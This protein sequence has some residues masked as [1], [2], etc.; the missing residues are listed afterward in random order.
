M[1]GQQKVI[2]R[3]EV[4][5]QFPNYG[6]TLRRVQIIFPSSF[7]PGPPDGTV[8]GFQELISPPGVQLDQCFRTNHTLEGDG[9][10]SNRTGV[11]SD[12]VYDLIYWWNT[13]AFSV[14]GSG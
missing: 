14:N 12:W 9:Y 8:T 3:P 6:A 13:L 1:S 4:L 5:I 2:A 10:A 11:S 7:S